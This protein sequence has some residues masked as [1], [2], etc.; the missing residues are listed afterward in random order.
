LS[1]DKFNQ[2]ADVLYRVEQD[3]PTPQGTFHVNICPFPMGPALKEEIPEIKHVSRY[4][5]PGTL[6]LRYGDKV[7]F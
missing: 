7:F 5:Q 3:Q 1:F 2:N 4:A 6:L